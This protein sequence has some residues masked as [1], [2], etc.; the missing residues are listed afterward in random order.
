MITS[1]LQLWQ[2]ILDIV[3]AIGSTMDSLVTKLDNVQFNDTFILTKVFGLLHYIMGDIM[4]SFFCILIQ[5]GCGLLLW[6]LIKI[7]VNAV[8]SVIPGISG[9]VRIE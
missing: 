4:Y 7:V 9:K 2:Y 3:N 1:L 8:A 5:I 6:K